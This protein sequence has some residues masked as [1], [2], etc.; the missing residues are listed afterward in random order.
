MWH[1]KSGQF[2]FFFKVGWDVTAVEANAVLIS[3]LHQIQEKQYQNT[4]GTKFPS[5]SN[6]IAAI[7]HTLTPQYHYTGV[8]FFIYLFHDESI[9]TEDK[10][11][12][13]LPI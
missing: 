8:F 4:C 5:S 7:Q 13:K 1:P 9:D 12:K 2:D 11:I 6:Y 10:K 3:H